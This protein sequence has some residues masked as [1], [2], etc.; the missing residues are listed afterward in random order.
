M[1][2]LV[3]ALLGEL[4]EFA[5]GIMGSKRKK[6]SNQAILGSI[7]FSIIG[8]IIFAPLFFG[9]GAVIGAFAGAFFG[10]FIVEYLK[11]KNVSVA[12]QSGLGAF[13]GKLGGTLVK[14]VIGVIMITITLIQ[15]F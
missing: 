7:F 4:M 1:V 11:Q 12:Y 3:L 10:A 9:L 8:A 13:M 15:V 5:L 6:S 2:L 14:S